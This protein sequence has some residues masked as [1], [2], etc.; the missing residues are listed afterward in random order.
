MGL[1]KPATPNS[2]KKRRH[3]GEN[4]AVNGIL[5]A[6]DHGTRADRQYIISWLE[7]RPELENF[8]ASMLRSGTLQKAMRARSQAAAGAELGRKFPA[9]RG[10]DARRFK[11][12]TARFRKACVSQW[13]GGDDDAWAEVDD[14]VKDRLFYYALATD[15]KTP[16]PTQHDHPDFEG[17]MFLVLDA[18]Y[19][20]VGKRLSGCTP[21]LADSWGYFRFA[22]ETP[23]HVH[24]RLNGRNM[25]LNTESMMQ[26]VNDWGLVDNGTLDARLFSDTLDIG[27]RLCK[28]YEKNFGVE[29]PKHDEPFEY[30]T[31]AQELKD[32]PAPQEDDEEDTSAPATSAPADKTAAP[33]SSSSQASTST[34]ALASV[35]NSR[36]RAKPKAAKTSR[37]A[38]PPARR[39]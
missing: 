6:A 13:V 5:A 21:A 34:S 33:A 18:R 23:Q 12:L 1:A 11:S 31:A 10:K 4:A 32:V 37:N 16:I 17:P 30:P 39:T 14:S 3:G 15:P 9:M 7:S 35:V 8:I 27:Q 2:G 22:K 25:A 36:A 28:L 29:L 24:C 38:T 20:D 26:Q 19:K